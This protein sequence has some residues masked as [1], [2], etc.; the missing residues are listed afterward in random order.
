MKPAE[1]KFGPWPNGIDNLHKPNDVQVDQYGYPQAVVDAVNVDFSFDGYPSTRPGPQL[2]IALPGAHSIAKTAVG[3][4][5]VAASV[6]YRLTKN[7]DTYAATAIGS[8][9][10]NHP[11]SFDDHLGGVLVSNQTSLKRITA[12]GMFNATV[13]DGV[14]PALVAGASGGL[15]E[16]RYGIAVA[17]VDQFGQEGACSLIKMIDVAEGGGI[18]VVAPTAP[19]AVSVRLFRTETN[20]KVLFRVTDAAP[21]ATVLFGAGDPLGKEPIADP[22]QR[23]QAMPPGDFVNSW[24]AAGLCLVARGRFLLYSLPRA[25]HLHSAVHGFLQFPRKIVFVRAVQKG[26]YVGTKGEDV[27]FLA[28]TNPRVWE[29]VSTGG[30]PAAARGAIVVDGSDLDQAYQLSGQ[31]VAVWLSTSG[32]VLGTGNGSIIEPQASRFKNQLPQQASI[33]LNGARRLTAVL[34]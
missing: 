19:D 33:A 16:G 6:V 17:F 29:L 2:R 20:G 24:E 12:A 1:A 28:G 27:Y 10:S 18:T 3:T 31:G 7:G 32:F 25:Y 34:T 13:T 8:L 26:V 15:A 11:T 30:Q 5:C 23:A 4:Y 22:R 21:G 14:Q 9:N